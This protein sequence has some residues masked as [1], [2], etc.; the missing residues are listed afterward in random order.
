[1][2]APLAQLSRVKP[3]IKAGL[4]LR[5]K[6]SGNLWVVAKVSRSGDV[7]YRRYENGWAVG[8]CASRDIDSFFERVTPTRRTT[9]PNE[10]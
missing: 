4:C 6:S 9:S 8:V 10:T 7:T 1:M 2:P 3:K 5:D